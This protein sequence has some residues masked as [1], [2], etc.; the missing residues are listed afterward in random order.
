MSGPIGLA[1]RILRGRLRLFAGFACGLLAWPVLARFNPTQ[2]TAILAWDIGVLVFLALSLEL[3]LRVREPDRM[4]ARAE[5][6]EDGEWTIFWLTVAAITASF[7]V[8]VSEFA[9]LKDLHGV[10]KA[11]HLAL[12][13]V[14]LL[15]S[16]LMTHMTFA[17]R[18]AHE[19]YEPGAGGAGYRR[20][21]D[22]PREDNPD[23][24]DFAYF[25]L[26]LGMTFQ[27]SDVQI[28]DRRLRRLASL[29]AL[30]GFIFNTVILALTVNLA[31]GLL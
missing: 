9:N 14:T 30:L 26:V 6:Q 27:V 1:W 23:Y 31:A 16:W 21:L 10:A 13:A 25:A 11:V 3:F 12:V 4:A 15:V 7:A 24:W 5:A 28:T 29:H 2:A 19:Y 20:G 18:Y 17:F 22:F 8:I